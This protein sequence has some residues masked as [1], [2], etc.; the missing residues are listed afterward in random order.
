MLSDGAKGSWAYRNLRKVLISAL[1][2]PC[3][4]YM[5]IVT[6]ELYTIDNFYSNKR[7]DIKPF[8]TLFFSAIDDPLGTAQ[9]RATNDAPWDA[10]LGLRFRSIPK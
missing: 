6:Y 9:R 8:N 7:S 2:I 4:L 10:W 1:G 5:G 3:I